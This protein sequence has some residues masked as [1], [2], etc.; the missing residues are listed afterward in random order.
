MF[1]EARA[2]AR[3]KV[4]ADLE[5]FLAQGGTVTAVPNGQSGMP[6][7]WAYGP[8]LTRTKGAK[9]VA[10]ATSGDFDDGEYAG[11]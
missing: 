6:E 9:R 11:G 1:S 3:K 7:N 2:A 8:R 5:K 10:A 4:A